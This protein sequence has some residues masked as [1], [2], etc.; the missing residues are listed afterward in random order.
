MLEY[1]TIIDDGGGTFNTATKTLT[2]DPIT[3]ATGES[4]ERTFAIQIASS[5]P[6][7]PA[8]QSNGNSYDCIMSTTY[9][10]NLQIPVS[11]PMVKGIENIVGDLPTVGIAANLLFSTVIV[12]TATFFY[13]RTR[14]MK[15]EIKLIRH[16][17]NSGTI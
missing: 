8:G 17:L 10:S 5:I 12:I 3:V 2:W 13:A 7:T 4:Q 1:S 14:Q 11:C 16:N 6:A 9:G 15:K